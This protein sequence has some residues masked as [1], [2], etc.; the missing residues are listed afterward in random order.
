[1]VKPTFFFFVC[2]SLT[3]YCSTLTNDFLLRYVFFVFM[4]GNTVCKFLELKAPEVCCINA[5]LYCVGSASMLFSTLANSKLARLGFGLV[6]C[7]QHVFLV[8]V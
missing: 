3:K 1:M 8:Q 6:V 5:H 2:V 4:C 7:K